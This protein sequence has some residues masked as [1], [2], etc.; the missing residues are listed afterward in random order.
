MERIF[1]ESVKSE[2][3]RVIIQASAPGYSQKLVEGVYLGILEMHG[4]ENGKVVMTKGAPYFEYDIT[5]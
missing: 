2:D 3:R 4:T 1:A 5:W